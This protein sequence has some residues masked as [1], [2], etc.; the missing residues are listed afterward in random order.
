LITDL[1]PMDVLLQRIG[2]L[3][4]RDRDGQRPKGFDAAKAI[5]L[6]AFDFDASL[7]AIT[8]DR[9]GPHGLGGR[10]ALLRTRTGGGPRDQCALRSALSHQTPGAMHDRANARRQRH[11]HAGRWAKASA[12]K[13]A[14]DGGRAG[15]HSWGSFRC[16]ASEASRFR[17]ASASRSAP[18]RAMVRSAE[19]RSFRLCF[20]D[21]CLD[22][23]CFAS[24]I[25]Q[26]PFSYRFNGYAQAVGLVG[27]FRICRN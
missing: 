1:A 26:R 17:A 5:V 9:N 7:A 8:R 21:A 13:I 4:R 23:A 15:N 19:R 11:C 25:F 22:D 3:H 14:A 6:T 24:V 18:S 27:Q 10:S 20:D 12:S 16:A 2:Q